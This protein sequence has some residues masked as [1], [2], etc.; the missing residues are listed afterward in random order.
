MYLQIIKYLAVIGVVLGIGWKVYDAGSDA[1]DVEW[2]SK[3]DAEQSRIDKANLEHEKKVRDLE[4][5]LQTDAD[6]VNNDGK[7]KSD[8]LQIDIADGRNTVDSVREQSEKF[9]AGTGRCPAQN[10]GSTSVRQTAASAAVVLSKLYSS[11]EQRSQELAAAYDKAKIAG[12]ACE[13][14][15]NSVR[16]KLNSRE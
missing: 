7:A 1:K 11:C 13:A 8:S 9:A 4:S 3:W 5:K 14:A 6:E 2:Q 12:D 10:T 15:Y 16:E